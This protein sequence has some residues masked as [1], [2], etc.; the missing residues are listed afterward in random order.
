MNHPP[1]ARKLG[2]LEI[3]MTAP[4]AQLLLTL[5]IPG[6]VIY[7]VATG[8]QVPDPLWV[9]FGAIITFFFSNTKRPSEG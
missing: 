3:T 1:N 8:Q 7:L 4:W 2:P 6:A 5:L 9:A